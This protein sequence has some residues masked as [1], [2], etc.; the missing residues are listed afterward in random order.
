MIYRGGH[1]HPGRARMIGR[2][3][4]LWSWTDP[5]IEIRE[6]P[7]RGMGSFAAEFIGA[8]EI[9]TIWGGVV[10]TMKEVRRGAVKRGTATA[11]SERLVIASPPDAPDEPEA[12]HYLNHS[13]DPNLWMA[14]EATLIAR[15]DIRAGDELTADY[16]MWEADEKFVARWRCACESP[17]CRGLVTGRDWR[18]PDLQKRYREHFS[19]FINDRIAR[20]ER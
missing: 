14:D 9:V 19:P 8:G 12:A 11:I 1:A 5:R 20:L 6:A 15:R 3:Y 4:R 10:C 16:A 13:C 18:L 7:R 2:R 17:L